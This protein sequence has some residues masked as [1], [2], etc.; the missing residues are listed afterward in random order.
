MRTPIE[1]PLWNDISKAPYYR[2]EDA[3]TQK[4]YQV[5]LTHEYNFVAWDRPFVLTTELYYK[6]C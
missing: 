6:Y 5:V 3:T 4:S 2:P 1:I